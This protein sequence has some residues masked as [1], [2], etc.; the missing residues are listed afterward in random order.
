M[1]ERFTRAL[2]AARPAHSAGGRHRQAGDAARDRADW[3]AASRE[4]GAHVLEDPADVAIM[5]QLGHA[6]K[7]QGLVTEA[8]VAYQQAVRADPTDADARLQLG[9]ALRLVGRDQDAVAELADAVRLNGSEYAV[10]ELLALGETDV[11]SESLNARDTA[12]D[13]VLIEIGDLFGYIYHNRTLSG[14]QRVMTNIIDQIL[15]LPHEQQDRYRFVMAAADQM[16][17]QALPREM[18]RRFIRLALA[19]PSGNL[20]AQHA[21]L[22]QSMSDL[23][24]EG[25]PLQPVA[26]QTFL[27]L[28]AFWANGQVLERIR[29]LKAR[30][31]RIGLYLYDLIPLTHGE[32]F[33][34]A[35]TSQFVFGLGD[36]LVSI[37]FVITISEH[38]S[39]QMRHVLRDAG[40]PAVPVEAVTLAHVLMP[41]SRSVVERQA[42][43]GDLAILR[44]RP[45]VLSVST[46]EARKN[47]VYLF[48]AWRAMIAAGES[49]P[50]LVLIGRP[51]W[52]IDDFLTQ[53]KNVDYLDGRIHILYP[54]SDADLAALY[55]HCL[56]SVFPS[57]VEG[58][59]LPVGESLAFGT[60]C[61]ASNTS[62]IPEVGGDFVEYFDPHNLRDG[63]AVFRRMLFT[64]GYLDRARARIDAEFRP[65]SWS[66]VR[67]D[68]LATIGR[69]ASP[70]PRAPDECGVTFPPATV[71]MPRHYA[72]GA[73][74][75]A[76]YIARP[77]PAMLAA[78]WYSI[79]PTGAWMRYEAAMLAFATG[80]PDTD[81][82]VYIQVFGAPQVDG[83]VLTIEPLHTPGQ[84]SR[85]R[86]RVTLAPGETHSLRL[87]LR[88][89]QHG[90]VDLQLRLDRPARQAHADDLRRFSVG[91][92]ALAWVGVEDHLARSEV[93]EQLTMDCGEA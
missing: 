6:L 34:P 93:I 87:A 74:A 25:I 72:Q 7:E 60:P 90:R 91:L 14:I 92:R 5:V 79:E 37:D 88:T 66:D 8:L 21:T 82:L 46:I 47:H 44:S 86:R 58:W 22:R 50:D 33:V 24:A 69:L 38:V 52:M 80:R 71:F 3:V 59:G 77:F 56:F 49:V 13:V 45:F 65:R 40:L 30:G 55:R 19:P 57:F 51:G 68:F 29:G 42:W 41:P 36:L 9:R 76:N 10:R 2:S 63:L 73:V 54:V 23:A 78:G 84:G 20:D 85:A 62:A 11:A 31:C 43:T 32:Y 39:G 27:V 26:G 89:D 83:D 4:Y 18:L 16:Q 53:L 48:S 67:D 15:K 70:A 35:V 61:A 17:S 64:E 1:L 12:A 81:I 75:P 28:G